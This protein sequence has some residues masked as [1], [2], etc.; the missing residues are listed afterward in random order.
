MIFFLV[1][2][3][4]MR[5]FLEGI[6]PRLGFHSFEIKHHRGKEDLISNLD[7]IIPSLSKR[8]QQIIVII[9]QD[10]QDCVALKNEIE[11]K[12]AHC[13]CKHKIRIA[14]YEL[15]AWFLGDMAAIAKCSP[16]FKA[17]SFQTKDKY[18]DID[19]IEKPSSVIAKIV[20]DWKEKYA[21]KPKFAQT[22]AQFVSLERQANRSHSFHVLLETLFS[23]SRQ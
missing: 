19:N 20:P 22:I 4:S 9:D 21:S 15:E 1:E 6:L 5:Q 10:K 2:D 7:K 23:L 8:A 11:E 14:C 12:M 3:Y 13:S 16:R 17:R 18:R